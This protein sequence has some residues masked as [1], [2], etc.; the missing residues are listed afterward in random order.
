MQGAQQPCAGLKMAA[1]TA[2]FRL[3]R[4]AFSPF[5]VQRCDPWAR[6]Q[7]LTWFLLW[8]SI[9]LGL[10]SF[11]SAQH[12]SYPIEGGEY[13]PGFL[14]VSGSRKPR[15]K[16]IPNKESFELFLWWSCSL[17]FLEQQRKIKESLPMQRTWSEEPMILKFVVVLT[18]YHRN[19]TLEATKTDFM[20]DMKGKKILLLSARV[21]QCS[22]IPKK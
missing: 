1:S 17:L 5:L 6:G 11:V 13:R 2:W 8:I 21:I 16:E 22:R 18:A 19:C 14:I 3:V 4:L 20:F 15:A 10:A 9:P 12:C 7:G